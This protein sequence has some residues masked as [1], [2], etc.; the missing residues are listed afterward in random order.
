MSAPSSESIV[1]DAAEGV[2]SELMYC[3]FADGLALVSALPTAPDLHLAPPLMEVRHAG[4]RHAAFPG[5]SRVRVDPTTFISFF[6]PT[7]T[8]L[9]AARRELERRQY[10]V[11]SISREDIARVCA[12]IHEMLVRDKDEK[13]GVD[14]VVLARVIQELFADRL[15]YIRYLLDQ[16][17]VLPANLSAAQAQVR[18]LSV[19]AAVRKQIM[20]ALS[21]HMPRDGVDE[22]AWY[23]AIAHGCARS[24]TAHLPEERFTKQEH[25]I[26]HAIDEVLHEVCRVLTDAWR[27]AYK[28][29]IPVSDLGE[30]TFTS[31]ELLEKW[32]VAFDA[33]FEW[34]DWPIWMTCDP[35]CAVD[36]GD[37]LRST[38]M[39]APD[40][41][42]TCVLGVLRGASTC[43]V[44]TWGRSPS[45]HR[46][47]QRLD[48]GH[49]PTKSTTYD[50]CTLNGVFSHV[51]PYSGICS[52][53][54]IV[55]SRVGR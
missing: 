24:F 15:L 46:D 8:S 23:E 1:C 37:R 28:I 18:F 33:L 50:N 25:I 53:A 54:S 19:T 49:S 41:F 3:A 31:P 47:R 17:R 39:Y 12:D 35:A 36:V 55:V 43:A 16:A 29:D 4:S 9:V 5:E 40:S 20:I 10:R 11:A 26:Q 48:I 38:C 34:L 6:D 2:R 30:A 52:S 51:A 21:P 42:G 7:L 32:R 44:A 27:D 22:P 45:V 14:W 13:S